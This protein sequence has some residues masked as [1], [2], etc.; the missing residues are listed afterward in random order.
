M[1]SVD[2]YIPGRHSTDPRFTPITTQTDK[3][4]LVSSLLYSL[5]VQCVTNLMDNSTTKT[6]QSPIAQ[7]L[8]PF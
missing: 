5:T 1:S 4:K 6:K 8:F 2:R 7:L 3:Q